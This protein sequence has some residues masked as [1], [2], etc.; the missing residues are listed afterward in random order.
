MVSEDAFD[1][2]LTAMTAGDPE[3][4]PESHNPFDPACF[5]STG[6][7]KTYRNLATGPLFVTGN[8]LPNMPNLPSA[9]NTCRGDALKYLI[10][11]ALPLGDTALDP[12]TGAT[13]A[14]LLGLAIS[15]RTQAL[16]TA[17]QEWMT[18]CL[19][20]HL[21]GYMTP[22][23]LLLEG[24][25]TGF[26][27]NSTL[28]QSYDMRDSITWGNIFNTDTPRMFVCAFDDAAN[29]CSGASVPSLVNNRVCD[30]STWC[31]LVYM[32]NCK[33]A[34]SWSVM[35]TPPNYN[36]YWTCGTK[37]TN[38]RVRLHDFA[39]YSPDCPSN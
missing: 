16:D 23:A 29:I 3:D 26:Y 36:G 8:S 37:Q 5:W 7:Q 31:G 33:T 2:P 11:C 4:P 17:G 25:R 30:E 10:R 6:V 1:V 38:L 18:S 15:W 22:A 24:K 14:G 20:A 27:F 39:M 12:V 9:S 21:N 34:C 35:G 28:Q 32:G 19:G 13:Y